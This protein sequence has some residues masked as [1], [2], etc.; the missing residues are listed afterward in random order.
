MA[1]GNSYLHQRL[2]LA[3]LLVSLV[4]ISWLAFSPKPDFVLANFGDKFKHFA[5]FGYL[6]YLL[7]SSFPKTRFSFAK[8]LTL[9]GY[10]LFIEL[11]QS[12]LPNRSASGLDVL[13]DIGGIFCYWLLTPLWKRLPVINW[14]W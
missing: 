3:C 8:V 14:R 6:A 13:A 9:L 7:D 10:G 5:A 12:F 1:N 2:S 11:V 4:V